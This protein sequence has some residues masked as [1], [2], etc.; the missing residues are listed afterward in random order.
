LLSNNNIT[1]VTEISNLFSQ[2]STEQQER[3]TKDYFDPNIVKVVYQNIVEK[4]K[5]REKIWLRLA[6]QLNDEY[7]DTLDE[8]DRKTFGELYLNKGSH[9]KYRPNYFKNILNR[10]SSNIVV[11]KNFDFEKNFGLSIKKATKLFFI[12]SG[13]FYFILFYFYFLFLFFI[14]FYFIL[15]YFIFYFINQ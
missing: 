9:S 14:L 2:E 11:N 4:S 8:D 3:R 10:I 1:A 13:I 5:S 6:Q 12:A 7:G 15:F